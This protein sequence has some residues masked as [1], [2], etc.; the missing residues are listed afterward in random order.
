MSVKYNFLHQAAAI[1]AGKNNEKN[2]FIRINHPCQRL[3]VC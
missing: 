3:A 2:H 1:F